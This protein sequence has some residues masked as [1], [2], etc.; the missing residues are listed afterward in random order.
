[1][2]SRHSP[3]LAAAASGTPIGVRARRLT[4]RIDTSSADTTTLAAD[5]GGLAA[6]T[7]AGVSRCERDKAGGLAADTGAG[8][9]GALATGAALGTGDAAKAI[10]KALKPGTAVLTELNLHFRWSRGNCGRIAIGTSVLTKLASLA[11]VG[12]FLIGGAGVQAVREGEEPGSGVW[13]V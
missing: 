6:D 9:A 7:G 4:S 8:G 11:S 1:M 13:I 12:T 10:A 2:H 3:R 5:A